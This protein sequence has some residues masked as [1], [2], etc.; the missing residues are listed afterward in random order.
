MISSKL[1]PDHYC[2]CFVLISA[3]CSTP[4]AVSYLTC[5]IIA[6]CTIQHEANNCSDSTKPC[7]LYTTNVMQYNTVACFVY[8]FVG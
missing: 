8:L 7:E 1:Q 2:A 6:E 3:Y 4:V 5:M